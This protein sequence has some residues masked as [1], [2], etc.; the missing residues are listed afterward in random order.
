MLEP[1]NKLTHLASSTTE[2]R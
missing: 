2:R 1:D